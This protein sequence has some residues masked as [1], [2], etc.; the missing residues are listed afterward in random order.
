MKY[1]FFATAFFLPAI[2]FSQTSV[3]LEDAAKH[4]GDSVI[5]CGKVADAAF[6]ESMENSPTFLNLGGA[7]PN[8]LLNLVIWK[9]QRSQY[10]PAPELQFVNKNVCVTGKIE[11]IND[12]P[13]IVIYNKSQLKVTD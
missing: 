10:D 1:I 12:L 9:D 13:E 5:V 4:I 7:Y 8:Q 2:L 6:V 11:M 3:K